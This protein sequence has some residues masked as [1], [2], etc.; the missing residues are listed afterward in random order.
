MW[1]GE[2]EAALRLL[3]VKFINDDVWGVVGSGK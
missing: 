2:A 3:G 1:A